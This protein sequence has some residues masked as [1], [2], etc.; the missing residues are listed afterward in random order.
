MT[1]KYDRIDLKEI[2]PNG[3]G[4]HDI[5]A[6]LDKGKPDASLLGMF[7][8]ALLAV[9]EVGTYG[10]EKYTRGGWEGVSDGI[11]RYT[12]AMLRHYFAERY[13]IYDSDLPVLHAAQV[14]WN[15][16]ARLELMLRENKDETQKERWSKEIDQVNK[17][18]RDSVRPCSA[19]YAESYQNT[20]YFTLR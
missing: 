6:K 12:A 8:K 5:G 7:G 1:S 13:D 18:L 15:A 4:Q 17:Q 10:A 11:N 16:L 19:T 9:A 14:A 20:S 2:D 3:I